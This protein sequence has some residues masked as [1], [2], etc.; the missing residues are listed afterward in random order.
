M[1]GLFDR[2]N[3]F[4]PIGNLG[5]DSLGDGEL[6]VSSSSLELMFIK[7][8]VAPLLPPCSFGA[9]GNLVK[10]DGMCDAMIIK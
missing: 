3:E 7:G 1:D 9:M 2:I 8:P 10:L 4:E 6:S 5:L